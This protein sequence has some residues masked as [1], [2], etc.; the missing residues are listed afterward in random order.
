M[1]Q[2][3][4]PTEEAE[5][6]EMAPEAGL[7]WAELEVARWRE[8]WLANEAASGHAE[9]LCWV[10]EHWVLL[11]GASMAFASIQ[12]ELAQMPV[13]QPPEL[14]Q[15]MAR[16]GRLLAGHRQHNAVAPGLWWEVA[17]DAGKALLGLAEVLAVMRAQMEIDLG[18]GM[19]GVL[20]EE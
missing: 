6:R 17:A 4:K 9:I 12:D 5:E 13:G 14:Q 8:D 15:G 18:V 19:A 10:Q 1:Q 20:G 11:D 3:G 2:E 16:V 7:L